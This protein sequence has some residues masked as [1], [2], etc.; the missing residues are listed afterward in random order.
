M[1]TER[2]A[3]PGDIPGL[4]RRG[5][6]VIVSGPEAGGWY[7]PALCQCAGHD[8]SPAW[9][10]CTSAIHGWAS[11]THDQRRVVLDLTDDTG[12]F[13]ARLY[14]RD[15]YRARNERATEVTVYTSFGG[16][17][18][19]IDLMNACLYIAGRI[20]EPLYRD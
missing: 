13:H 3:L 10:T 2:P 6:P 11:E 12:K 7:Y 17:L 1:T 19:E 4:L 9:V 15:Q 14:L 18:D 5:S 16:H 20:D 8:T